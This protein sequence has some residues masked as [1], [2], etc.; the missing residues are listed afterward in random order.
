MKTG[1]SISRRLELN[2]GVAQPWL[3]AAMGVNSSGVFKR[4]LN[5]YFD[6]TKLRLDVRSVQEFALGLGGKFKRPAED[7]ATQRINQRNELKRK[8]S[9]CF[10]EFWCRF[11]RVT[12]TL[13]PVGA[14][15]PEKVAYQKAF[16]AL[17]MTE[18]QKAL[19]RA[20]ME[21]HVGN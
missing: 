6:R 5:D 9:E 21:M 10:K 8:P 16:V 17:S 4:M 15:W 11:E 14:Q 20:T 13:S 3:L 7:I 2:D 1:R 19:V 18:D 12:N